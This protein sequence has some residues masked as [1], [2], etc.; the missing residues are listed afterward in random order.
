MSILDFKIQFDESL[1]LKN[2]VQ[3]HYLIKNKLI[4]STHSTPVFSPMYGTDGQDIMPAESNLHN[5][6]V[7]QVT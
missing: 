3:T 2:Q 6:N 4:N 7:L 1:K 5:E